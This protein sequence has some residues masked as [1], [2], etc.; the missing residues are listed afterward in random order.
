MKKLLLIAAIVCLAAANLSAQ[1]LIVRMDDIGATHSENLAVIHCYQNG[2]GRSAEVMTVCPWF[3]EAASMLNENPKLDVGIHVVFCAEW[4]AYKWKP[5]TNCKSIM[6]EDGY[7]GSNRLAFQGDL[8]EME[9]EMR[10]Q[11]EL[12]LKY[13]KNV[14]HITDHCMWTM[15]PE[16]KEMA[17]RVAKEYGLR[18]QGQGDYDLEIGINS[19]PMISPDKE[20]G[21]R[22]EAFLAALKTMEKGKTYWT[23]EHPAFDNEEM[24]GIYHVGS[25]NVGA[26][27]QDVTDT[28]TNPEIMK[29]IKDNGIELISFGD[30]IREYQNK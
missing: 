19:L 21:K 7:L 2:I 15:R 24:K 29:Y 23:I 26:D 6:N 14:T 17:I 30:V 20:T 22:A 11:I 1:R 18:Y 28:F 5:L 25:T 8:K 12:G 27:R 13:C 16:L 10:A 4:D 3:L 9:A